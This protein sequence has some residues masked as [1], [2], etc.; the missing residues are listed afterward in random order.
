MA[1]VKNASDMK[2]AAVLTGDG[3]VDRLL[4]SPASG[5]LTW[6]VKA[7]GGTASIPVKTVKLTLQALASYPEQIE[8]TGAAPSAELDTTPGTPVTVELDTA[9]LGWQGALQPDA[10]AKLALK[11]DT[12]AIR[13]YLLETENIAKLS[14]RLDFL[15]A[16][17]VPVKDAQGRPFSL[18]TIAQVL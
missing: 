7:T 14:V 18:T 11:L 6:S 15:A 12:E 8:A 9:A 16:D 5:T 1:L 3:A 2:I 13:D 17:G 10:E 4:F